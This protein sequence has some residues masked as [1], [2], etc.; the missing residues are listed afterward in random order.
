MDKIK[1]VKIKNEDGSISE[2]SYTISVDARNVDMANG[3]ELQETIGTI[4]I[5]TDGNIAEQLENLND[6]VDE[7]NIDIKKKAYFFNSVTDMKVANL[8]VGDYAC[9]LGYYEA[10]DGGAGDYQ[11]VSGNYTDDGGS[12]LKLKNN[13]YAKLIIKKEINIKQFGA[14]GDGSHDDTQAIQNAI[15]LIYNNISTNLKNNAFKTRNVVLIPEGIY[16]TKST[17]DLPVVVRILANGNP[18]ILVD[19]D[20]GA[21][22]YLNSRNLSHINYEN[23]NDFQNYIS[24]NI[25]DSTS[26]SLTIEKKD[27]FFYGDTTTTG[28]IGLEVGDRIFATTDIS[29]ISRCNFNNINISGFETGLAL[30]Y[31]N[32]YIVTFNNF[33]IQENYYNVYTSYHDSTGNSGEKITFKDCLLGVSRYGVYIR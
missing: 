5:D 31:S 20:E 25:I 15:N 16:L 23:R 26:G 10:N 30:N 19:F 22:I 3:K 11:I 6:N 18:K 24:G 9:T 4:D 21:G 27:S 17:I 12:Y 7:L 33:V 29:A 32:L 8:K 14:Y 2:E 1:T 13:L 28:S